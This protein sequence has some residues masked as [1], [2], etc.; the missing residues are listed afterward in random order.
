MTA[1]RYNPQRL[2]RRIIG[3][4]DSIFSPIR[5]AVCVRQP[6]NAGCVVSIEYYSEL[7]NHVSENWEV[8]ARQKYTDIL[9][10]NYNR[11]IFAVPGLPSFLTRDFVTLNNTLSLSK[12]TRLLAA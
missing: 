10:F 2:P 7:L 9:D 11:Y 12:S 1:H 8:L 3:R 5:T 4:R 6:A